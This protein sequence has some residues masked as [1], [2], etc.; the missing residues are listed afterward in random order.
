MKSFD[1]NKDFSKNTGKIP[2][3]IKRYKA[4]MSGEESFFFDVSDFVD[5]ISYFI[6][7]LN[8][9]E[10]QQA[11]EEAL[12]FYPSESELLFLQSGLLFRKGKI[13]EALN[14]LQDIEGLQ[15]G[16]PEF[17]FLKANILVSKGKIKTAMKLYNKVL[18][19]VDKDEIPIYLHLI[20]KSLQIVNKFNEALIYFKQIPTEELEEEMLEDIATTYESIGDYNSAL[21]LYRKIL[22]MNVF[23]D[24]AW[25]ELGNLYL[26][27]ND[28]DKALEAF[29]YAFAIDNNLIDV[30]EKIADI[31]YKKQNY[32]QAILYYQ[33]LS[34]L[35]KNN[36]AYSESLADSY[37]QLKMFEKAEEYYQ[38][39]LN[40]KDISPD[41]YHGLAIIEYERKNFKKSLSLINK[42]IE[43][44]DGDEAL[45]FNFKAHVLN[46]LEQDDEALKY[47]AKAVV[48]SDI[49]K[50]YLTDFIEFLVDNDFVKTT[51]DSL[52]S[53][54]GD[55]KENILTKFIAERLKLYFVAYKVDFDEKTLENTIKKIV[56]KLK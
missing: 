24:F 25:E 4:H 1:N 38:K 37:L 2:P 31:Y 7:N 43:L 46:L 6:E 34:Q 8:F 54:I 27:L 29:L 51:I 9:K 23:S 12:N 22:K 28:T 13:N 20:G 10:A 5:I 44:E 42:A 18:D 40:N 26:K 36:N 32:K 11:I 17:Y 55:T 53:E 14:I 30:G 3:L 41:I 16:N 15:T 52:A 35:L 39:A 48:L 49:E 56:N 21:K 47:F 45:Y 19:T 50:D 33:Y